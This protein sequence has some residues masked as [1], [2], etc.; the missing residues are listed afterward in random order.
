MK[1]AISI[2]DETFEQVS[3][4]ALDLGISRS[5]FFATAVEQ[6]LRRLDRESLSAKIDE[7][8]A[9][10]GNDN[11]S[12]AAVDAGRRRLAATVADW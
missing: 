11:S 9:L 3:R 1:T 2:S 10:A 6:Y 7:A 4:R 12:G 8:V 5:R